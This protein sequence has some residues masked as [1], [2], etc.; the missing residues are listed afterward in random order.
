MHIRLLFYVRTQR[1][2]ATEDHSRVV[3]FEKKEH[4]SASTLKSVRS[5]SKIKNLRFSK[6]ISAVLDNF[7]TLY[8]IYAGCMLPELTRILTGQGLWR[9]NPV[10]VGK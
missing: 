7:R 2:V 6:M 5:K 1:K 10:W 4:S 8:A 3:I 9:S